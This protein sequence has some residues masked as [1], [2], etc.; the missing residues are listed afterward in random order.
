MNYLQLVHRARAALA[1]EFYDLREGVELFSRL[2]WDLQ[3][4]RNVALNNRLR[5]I[6]EINRT[7][8]EGIYGTT[9]DE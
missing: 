6:R 5:R 9:S 1:L 3:E 2:R 4:C 7:L 8:Q